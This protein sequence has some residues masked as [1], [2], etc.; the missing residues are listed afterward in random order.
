M[1]RLIIEPNGWPCRFDEC[2]P[3]FFL[4]GET[5]CLKSEYWNEQGASEAYVDSGEFFAGAP[6]PVERDAL[7]VQP[8]IARWIEE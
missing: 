6:A 7:L 2:P 8:C 1:K 3:G 5:L 4:A